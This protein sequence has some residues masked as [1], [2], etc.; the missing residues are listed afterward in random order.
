MGTGV[1]AS[2][3]GMVDISNVGTRVRGIWGETV[4][5]TDFRR[6]TFSEIDS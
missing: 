6:T 5:R 2:V 4:T 1:V 3:C